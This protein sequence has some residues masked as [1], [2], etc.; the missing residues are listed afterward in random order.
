MK[1]IFLYKGRKNPTK[2]RK[3]LKKGELE[4]L[5]KEAI[6]SIEKYPWSNGYAYIDQCR[7][8]KIDFVNEN[9]VPVDDF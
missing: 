2:V 3:L 8:I 6:E 7:D 9:K 1:I 4:A 5:K